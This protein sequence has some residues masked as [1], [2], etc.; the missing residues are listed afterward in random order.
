MMRRRGYKVRTFAHTDPS[1]HN[2]I[3]MNKKYHTAYETRP[4]LPLKKEQKRYSH[5]DEV[6]RDHIR[7]IKESF[8]ESFK[9]AG[10]NLE[11]VSD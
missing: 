9:K 3:V 8:Y 2:L 1:G 10:K 7:K 5:R 4:I 6:L 11:C